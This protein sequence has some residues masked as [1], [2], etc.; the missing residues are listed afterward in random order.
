MSDEDRF[1]SGPLRHDCFFEHDGPNKL[2][3]SSA[4]R[5]PMG[6]YYGADNECLIWDSQLQI[7]ESKWYDRHFGG[8]DERCL[9]FHDR[10]VRIVTRLLGHPPVSTSIRGKLVNV[11]TVR[12]LQAAVKEREKWREEDQRYYEHRLRRIISKGQKQKTLYASEVF[13]IANEALEGINKT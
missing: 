1:E 12:E 9:K 13:N 10:L 8:N 5:Y 2:C 3:I 11:N 6:K 4:Y 7:F